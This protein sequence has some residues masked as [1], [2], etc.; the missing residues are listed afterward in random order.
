[1]LLGIDW[2]TNMNGVISLKKRKMIFEK[3]SL[4]IEVPLDLV[5]GLCYIEPVHNYE[6]NDDLDYIYN[7]TAE[8]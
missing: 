4:R 1:M 7:I 5:E 3:R 8:E 2:A 6:S